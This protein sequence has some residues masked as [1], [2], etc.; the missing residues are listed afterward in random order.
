ML[1]QCTVVNIEVN[2][3]F[4]YRGKKFRT[5]FSHI[6]EMRSL[7]PKRTNVMALTATANEKTRKVIISSLEMFDCYSPNKLNIYY[8]A[9]TKPSC[10]LKCVRVELNHFS[11][12]IHLISIIT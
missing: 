4:V 5:D 9:L 6:G 3:I 7:L 10:V 11:L 12:N 1:C 8:S 2:F